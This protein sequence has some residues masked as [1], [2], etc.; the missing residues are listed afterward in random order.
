MAALTPALATLL[1]S[2]AFAAPAPAGA[3]KQ[4]HPCDAPQ[5][6]WEAKA[7]ELTPAEKNEIATS[8]SVS[9]G[10]EEGAIGASAAGF[11]CCLVNPGSKYGRPGPCA[12][13]D[14][15]E[16]RMMQVCGR[17]YWSIA[18]GCTQKAPG[19]CLKAIA[20][21]VDRLKVAGPVTDKDI[22]ELG[23]IYQDYNL[24]W[25]DGYA[26]SVR[27][28]PL[29]AAFA[30]LHTVIDS[31]LVEDFRGRISQADPGDK[32]SSPEQR[33]SALKA[34]ADA[35]RNDSV[36][37]SRCRFPK[38]SEDNDSSDSCKTRLIGAA[39][40]IVWSPPLSNPTSTKTQTQTKTQTSPSPVSPMA[41][42][43]LC[44]ACRL[45]CRSMGGSRE[46]CGAAHAALVGC[47]CNCPDWK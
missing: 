33:Q 26:V 7:A 30:P 27:N 47:A 3:P 4:Q 36:L 20:A 41:C 5:K 24:D 43:S 22:A 6:Q 31:R 21:A 37:T 19:P 15:V 11:S 46:S 28:S 35:L 42:D 40:P 9:A 16:P 25:K 12:W 45:A 18:D 23:K 8:P 44:Q 29:P 39:T 32:K 2:T 10:C 13:K 1:A 38:P 34:A 17:R 14:K